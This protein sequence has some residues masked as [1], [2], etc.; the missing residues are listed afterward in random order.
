MDWNCSATL[1]GSLPHKDAVEAIDTILS[2]GIDVPAWPQL[3]SRGYVESMYAQTGVRLPGIVIDPEAKTITVDLNC[4][5]PM[6]F[7]T[8]VISED[9]EYFCHPPEYFS[10]LYAFL[11]RPLGDFAA[12]KGQVTGPISEGLQI[13]DTHGRAVIYDEA[14]G[15]IIRK[16]VNMMAKW[17]VRELR[18]KNSQ[19]MIFFDEPTL[20]MLGTPF[21]GIS[22]KDAVDWINE[23]MEGVEAHKAIHCCGNTDW[24]MVMSTNTDILSFDAYS[25]GHTVA[26]YPEEMAAFLERGGTLAWG[27]VPNTEEGVS[28]ETADTLM[29][30]ME[31]HISSLAEKGLDTDL[32]LRRCLLT[33]QCGLGGLEEKIV[34]KVLKLLHELSDALRKRYSL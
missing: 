25:Y 9:L 31:I 13:I 4:Y 18:K 8:A 22:S 30:L 17:Q 11:E 14:Y 24:P 28:I 10:G 2:S 3:P 1:I 21:A 19:V 20:T 33:P 29:R 32:L 6:E 5:D 27:I 34:P 15:E 23:S 16:N 7:Y 12:L 26:L